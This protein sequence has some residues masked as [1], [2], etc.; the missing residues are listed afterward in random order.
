[1]SDV[2][3]LERFLAQPRNLVLAGIRRDGRPQLGPNWFVWGRPVLRV[4][5]SHVASGDLDH[6]FP[7]GIADGQCTLGVARSF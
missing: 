7:M 3:Q 6:D 2:P 5:E 4:H 1:M